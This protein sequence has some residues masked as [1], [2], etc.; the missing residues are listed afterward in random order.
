MTVTLPVSCPNESCRSIEMNP[1]HG[2]SLSPF[3]PVRNTIDMFVSDNLQK[4]LWIAL[5]SA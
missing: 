3:S 5:R 1:N 2:I 4:M